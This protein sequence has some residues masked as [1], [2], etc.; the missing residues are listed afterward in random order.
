MVSP[1]EYVAKHLSFR[2]RK[3]LKIHH[4]TVFYK[5]YALI[6][7]GEKKWEV[8]IHEKSDASGLDK[9]EDAGSNNTYNSFALNP[10]CE[11]E[12]DGGIDTTTIG[13]TP[14]VAS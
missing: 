7:E 5:V 6:R 13:G 11:I 10:E 1:A 8:S 14:A 3:S 2:V 4:S 9:V 12:V